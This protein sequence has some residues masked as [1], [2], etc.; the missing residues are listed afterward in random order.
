MNDRPTPGEWIAGSSA[1]FAARECIAVTDTDNDTPARYAANA[2]LMAAA[3]DLRAALVEVLAA[4]VR[5]WDGEEYSDVGGSVMT[6][7]LVWEAPKALALREALERSVD[8]ARLEAALTVATAAKFAGQK[9]TEIGIV[10]R[11][12]WI[13]DQLPTASDL[14]DIRNALADV[15]TALAVYGAAGT[16]DRMDPKLNGGE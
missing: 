3:P 9:I 7:R 8:A 13:R 1:V 2:R 12:G 4:Y 15:A 6:A 10:I 14:T 16:A 5:G 11:E